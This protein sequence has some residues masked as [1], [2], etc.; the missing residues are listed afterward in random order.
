MK[1]LP[2]DLAAVCR[3]M[4]VE[5]A[6][7]L[8]IHENPDADAVGAAV[9]MLDLF[10][11]IDVPAALYVSP[12]ETL[13]LQGMVLNHVTPMREMPPSGRALYVVDCGSRD[14]IALPLPTWDGFVVN[15]DHHHDNTRFG[16]LVFVRG[17][18]SSASE[19]VCDIARGL[20]L[21]PS[22][23]AA[24][25]LY[26]GISFDTGH[27]RHDSTSAA[28]FRCA[29][30]LEELGVEVTRVYAELYERRSLA[31]L[32]LWARAVD[33]AVAAADGR[34]LI[35]PLSNADYAATSATSDQTEG[36]VE[37]LRS[38]AG[39]E[40]AAL[41]REQGE[42]SAGVRV[43]IRSSTLDVSAVAALRGGGGHRLAAGFS[44]DDGLEEVI[45]WLSSELVRRLK[46]ASS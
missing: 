17:A 12:G 20:G 3:R 44:S 4:R 9:G 33:G 28:T 29:A 22:L 35:A 14:R 23:P 26:A 32:R 31:A 8:A 43:S 7:A 15:I 27:F 1:A 37:S 46:T 34:A 25:A 38:V 11:Q 40:V 21:A 24:T 41:V 42:G 6:A 5:T 39:V 2:G 19:M 45:A 18:A 13:P 10:R 16:D 30:W 36:I